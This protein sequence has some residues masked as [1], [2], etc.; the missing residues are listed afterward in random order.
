[1]ANKSIRQEHITHLNVYTL[2]NFKI[3][4]VKTDRSKRRNRKINRQ[5]QILKCQDF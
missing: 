3:Y 2:Y 1:M 5:N 4:E